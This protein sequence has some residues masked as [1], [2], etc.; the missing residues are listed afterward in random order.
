MK[1]RINDMEH[2]LSEKTAYLYFIGVMLMIEQGIK[3]ALQ[4]F[5]EYLNHILIVAVIFCLCL[6]VAG[7]EVNAISVALALILFITQVVIGVVLIR[8]IVTERK[9]KK[10]EERPTV[11]VQN[12]VQAVPPLPEV[13]EPQQN[14]P[15]HTF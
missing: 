6:T 15:M 5:W 4:W 1:A 2:R 8:A 10:N 14:V 11:T 7:L 13:S 3:S 9:V 12:V